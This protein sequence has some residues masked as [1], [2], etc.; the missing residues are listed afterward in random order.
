MVLNAG[1]VTEIWQQ[2]VE[3]LG[4]MTGDMAAKATRIAISGPNRL[5]VSVPA[6]YIKEY[7]ERPATRSRIEQQLLSITGLS[8][9]VDFEAAAEAAKPAAPMPAPAN[10]RLLMKERERNALVQQTMEVFGAEMVEVVEPR[11][12][13]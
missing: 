3:A 1:N 8:V 9:K 7:C 10:K 11:K 2:V 4:D 5:V 6:A 12:P 13:V